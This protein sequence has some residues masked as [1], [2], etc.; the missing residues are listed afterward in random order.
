MI[1][2]EE[3]QEIIQE[4]DLSSI[5]IGSLGSHS[6][7]DI[8]DGAVDEGFHTIVWAQKGREIPY[9]KYFKSLRDENKLIK[10]CVD[11]TRVLSS[12]KEMGSYEEQQWMRR[13]NVIIVPNRSLVSYLGIEFIEN[14]FQVPLFGSRNLLGIEE[15][16]KREKDYY[17]LLEHKI[18]NKELMRTPELVK[19]SQLHSLDELVIVKL[20]HAQRSLER[21]FITAAS[22]D[23]IVE[24]G[25]RLIAKNILNA[26][27][28]CQGVGC[29]QC[30][31]TG[32]DGIQHARIEK[33][34]IGPVFNFDFF[35]S[36]LNEALKETPLE[37][38][39]VDARFESSLDGL[40]RLPAKQQLSLSDKQQD[41][42]YIIVGHQSVTVRESLLQR[43]FEIAEEFVRITKELFYPGIIGP[44]TIQTTIEDDQKPTI[45]DISTRIG[46]GTNAHMWNGAPYG[47]TLWRSRMS[48]GRRIALELKRAIYKNQLSEIVS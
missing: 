43:V 5:K 24:K 7:L 17:W 34:S 14:N 20:H 26:C 33:Y 1:S 29:A 40:V 37:L 8:C 27:S 23:E 6:A 42:T 41:P 21:G 32:I 3:I 4:Y 22:F 10:G 15:R 45:Y 16:G 35:Y 31:Q 28:A 2:L 19:P 46:G 30:Y 9:T 38:L 13:K 47:N 36:P 39:G 44:F 18:T 25:K 48:T 12:F 11:Q